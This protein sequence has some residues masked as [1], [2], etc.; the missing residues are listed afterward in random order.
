MSKISDERRMERE[1]IL[2]FDELDK[3]LHI[4][5]FSPSTA[6][7]LQRR[8]WKIGRKHVGNDGKERGWWFELPLSALTI[9]SRS[10]VERV[11][12]PVARPATPA[13]G[14]PQGGVQTPPSGDAP[15]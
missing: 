14:K 3:V 11:P 7:L 10:S 4:N 8:G 5:T 9:R 15:Q 13:R 1:T 12:R 6:R 2:R